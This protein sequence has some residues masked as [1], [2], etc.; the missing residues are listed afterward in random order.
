M[1][2]VFVKKVLGVSAALVL[3]AGIFTGCAEVSYRDADSDFSAERVALRT[4]D[5]VNGVYNVVYV[6]DM[7]KLQGNEKKGIKA[8]NLAD[9]THVCLYSVKLNKKGKLAVTE[10]YNVKKENGKTTDVRAFTERYPE[11][12]LK[13]Y[14]EKAH[15][16]YPNVKIVACLGG[17]DDEIVDSDTQ[18][19]LIYNYLKDKGADSLASQLADMVKKYKLDGVDLDWEYFSSFSK[20]NSLYKDLAKALRNKL[21]ASEGYS[22]SVAFPVD[23]S[24]V[25][26]EIKEMCNYLDVVSVMSYKKKHYDVIKNYYQPKLPAS[27]LTYGISYEKE[28]LDSSEKSTIVKDAA[29]AKE[30]VNKLLDAGYK[31]IMAWDYK[32]DGDLREATCSAIKNY[33][34]SSTVPVNPDPEPDPEPEPD[35]DPIVTSDCRL[36]FDEGFSPVVIDYFETSKSTGTLYKSSSGAVESYNWSSTNGGSLKCKVKS[37]AKGDIDVY[38]RYKNAPVGGTLK[39]DTWAANKDF[40]KSIR[41]ISLLEELDDSGNVVKSLTGSGRDIPYANDYKFKTIEASKNIDKSSGWIHI[42]YYRDSAVS[43]ESVYIDN[44]M[45]K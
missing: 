21:P 45:I 29:T 14:L 2:K 35:P 19:T 7:D 41:K 4:S 20:Y 5:S 42:R 30:L 18:K 27:K 26:S 39:F 8:V 9:Y 17:G 34:S 13:S 37:S 32:G 6:P 1:L 33:K 44:F 38:I 40:G 3:G 16:N 25:D 22:L 31:G 36:T 23:K 28:N 11:S 12:T 43:G 15:K 24:F 10:S